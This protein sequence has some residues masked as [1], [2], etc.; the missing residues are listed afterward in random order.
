MT[1]TDTAEALAAEFSGGDRGCALRV[2]DIVPYF[3]FVTF[4]EL[5][6]Y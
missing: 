2:E 1:K 3:Y 6:T 4:G 5:L